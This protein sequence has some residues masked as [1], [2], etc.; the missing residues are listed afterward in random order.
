MRNFYKLIDIFKFL[1]KKI[2]SEEKIVLV[3]G[4][5][6][7]IGNAIFNFFAHSGYTVVGTSTTQGG[8]DKLTEYLKKNSFSGCGFELDVSSSE[9]IEKLWKNRGNA[10]E[11]TRNIY[12]KKMGE[13]PANSQENHWKTI[14]KC[15]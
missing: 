10:Q 8:A 11:R 12:E 1:E 6:R 4:A 3:T 13:R 14:G 2:L 5:S 15:P 9:S 7:G